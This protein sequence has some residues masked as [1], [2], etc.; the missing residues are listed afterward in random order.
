M[1]RNNIFRAN[2]RV[3]HPYGRQERRNGLARTVVKV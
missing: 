3:A 1:T 2:G